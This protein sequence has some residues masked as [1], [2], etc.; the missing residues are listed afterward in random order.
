MPSLSDIR[1]QKWTELSEPFRGSHINDHSDDRSRRGQDV[2]LDPEGIL[3][4]EA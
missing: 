3:E 1:G 4:Q 2:P